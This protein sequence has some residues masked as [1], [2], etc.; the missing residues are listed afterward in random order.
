MGCVKDLG[1]ELMQR[2]REE[3]KEVAYFE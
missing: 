3:N 2:K 1:K